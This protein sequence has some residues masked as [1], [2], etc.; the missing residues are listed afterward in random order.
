MG[1]KVTYT[2]LDVADKRTTFELFGAPITGANYDAQIALVSGI[3]AALDAITLATVAKE[4]ILSKTTDISSAIPGSPYA[5]RQ[6]KVLVR[7]HGTTSGEKFH[8]T[9]GAPDLGALTLESNGENIQ[10]DDS[11]GSGVMDDF[12]QAIQ[13]YG[14]NPEDDTDVL[15]VDEAILVGRNI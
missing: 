7:C 6:L 14:M 2:L 8:F 4:D 15:V 5:K 9:F 13:S 1:S 3:R 11:G 10:L 12:V